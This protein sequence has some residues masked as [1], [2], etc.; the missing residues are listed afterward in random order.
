MT[1]VPDMRRGSALLVVLGMLAFMLFSGLAFSVYMRQ[2]RLPTS[3]LR[4]T[5]TTRQLTKAALAEAIDHIDIA[6]G[7]DPHPGVRTSGEAFNE[8]WIDNLW[9]HRVFSGLGSKTRKDMSD[10]SHIIGGETVYPDHADVGDTVPTLTLEGLAY[11]PPNLI[12]EARY[13]SQ[14]TPT[15]KWHPFWFDSGRYA[16]TAIDVSDYFDVNRIQASKP[17]AATSA[18]RISFAHLF[19]EGADHSSAGSGAAQWDNFM[20]RFRDID[21]DTDE[22]TYNTYPFVSMADFNIAWGS[23]EIGGLSCPFYD[24]LKGDGPYD[25]GEAKEDADAEKYRGMTFVTDSYFPTSTGN[26]TPNT[27]REKRDLTT[28]Q[29]FRETELNGSSMPSMVD[30]IMGYSSDIV[31]SGGKGADLMQHLCGLG[32]VQLWDYL[33]ANRVPVS[34]AAPTLERV[35][36]IVGM[37]MDVMPTIKFKTAPSADVFNPA[38]PEKGW[39]TRQAKRT[40]TCVMTLEGAIGMQT[41]AA[42]PF[43]EHGITDSENFDIDGRVAVFFTLDGQQMTLRP[44]DANASLH[45]K[46][47]DV[48]SGNN[49]TPPKDSV[50]SFALQRQQVSG[51]AIAKNSAGPV[52]KI[53]LRGSTDG[54]GDVEFFKVTYQWEQHEQ[55]N[56]QGDPT[57]NPIEKDPDL[58]DATQI[59]QNAT[60]TS[61]SFRALMANGS[62]ATVFSDVGQF[63]QNIVNGIKIKANAAIWARVKANAAI[64]ARVKYNDSDMGNKTVDLVP[65]CVMDDDE[66]NGANNND[67]RAIIIGGDAYPLMRFDVTMQGQPD[68]TVTAT[69]LSGDYP[70]AIAVP[71]VICNDPRYNHQPENWYTISGTGLQEQDWINETAKMLG[72]NGCDSD[73]YMFTS[74]QGRMQSVYELAF[75]P[76]LTG[77]TYET[78]VNPFWGNYIDSQN[79]AAR[80]RNT[81]GNAASDALDYKSMWRTYRCFASNGNAADPFEEIGLTCG[82]NGPKVNPYSDSKK[83]LMAA[84]ANTPHDWRV[85]STDKEYAVIPAGEMGDAATFNKKHAWNAYSADQTGKMCWDCLEDLADRLMAKVRDPNVQA[86]AK[87]EGMEVW[88]YAF[89]DLDWSADKRKIL[90]SMEQLDDD[91]ADLYSVDKKFLYGF[92][93]DCFSARQQLFLI[94]VRA[95][96]MMM[97]GGVKGQI[98]PQLG[99]RAVALVWRD[100]TATTGTRTI[101]VNGQDVTVP[102]PHRT[103]ILFYHQFD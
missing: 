89:S 23:Q 27:N 68:V 44:G 33:D 1:N 97:G 102:N 90:D 10:P 49:V 60:E 81:F 59:S 58:T 88:D 29:P 31:N 83:V 39:G 32:L 76:R 26:K 86:S 103:R 50:F 100:P 101:K 13:Y 85:T 12:N 3:F 52:K 47:T 9:S 46:K 30:K 78:K 82:E 70:L 99:A 84:F 98:P 63:A 35:P 75:L 4:R 25:C 95:E 18:R 51:D 80:S 93:H 57:G 16:Y 7:N 6:I 62:Q 19:E 64:W 43:R 56:A 38:S 40:Y 17:R 8:N 92:W 34:L 72:Q 45:L 48:E 71:R 66:L 21:D 96:P 69:A 61:A 74:D 36:M 73:F 22:I 2:S 42:Y 41:L 14:R 37:E 53:S 54:F 77:L 11:L 94:F 24:F 87:S 15:A 55:V 20:K 91:D 65:A 79:A 5:A 67:S 28:Y